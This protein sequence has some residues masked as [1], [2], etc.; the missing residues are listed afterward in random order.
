MVPKPKHLGSEYAAQFKDRSIVEVYHYRPPYPSEVFEILSELVTD[1]PRTVLD[2]GC[3]TGDIARRL[4]DFVDRV[5]AVDFSV[6]M[7]EKGKRFP[8]G[9]HLNLNWICGPVE[10][11]PLQPPYALI[12]AGDSLHWMEWDIVFPRFK[13]VLTPKGYMAIVNRHFGIGSQ[14]EISIIS[15]YSTNQDY[16]PYDLVEELES[17]GL[18]QKRGETQTKFIPWRVSID[19][20]IEARHSQNGLSRDRMGKERAAAFDA[21]LRRLLL[22]F[23]REGKLELQV[24]AK[25]V[26]G[27]PK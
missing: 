27:I 6:G 14:E 3:G 10:E 24:Y 16:Q 5:D 23:C 17:R 21:E 7:I 13:Q 8:N 18:F 9:D 15:R 12:T 19:E 11:V 20:Y 2:T 1:K 25:V 26:W 4:V 22:R